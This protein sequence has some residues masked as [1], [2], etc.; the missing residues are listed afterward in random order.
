MQLLNLLKT[1]ETHWFSS[2]LPHVPPWSL[3]P[4][5]LGQHESLAARWRRS[6]RLSYGVG[7]WPT[8]SRQIRAIISCLSRALLGYWQELRWRAGFY[9]A[10]GFT[11]F[12]ASFRWRF[13]MMIMFFGIE[14]A[15][16][17]TSMSLYH[18]NLFY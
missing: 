16:P 12:K 4:E 8:L 7:T 18:E 13:S 14:R 11:T 6:D 1:T 17:G 10:A 3:W 9:P 5:V 15:L 2:Q